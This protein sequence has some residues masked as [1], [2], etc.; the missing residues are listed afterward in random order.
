MP[1]YEKARTK[2]ES[3]NLVYDMKNIKIETATTHKKF[4]VDGDYD[5]DFR[6]NRGY[7][8][9]LSL[10]DN[11][12][13]DTWTQEI[14]FSDENQKI[15]WI[16][17]IYGDKE[18][19]KQGPFGQ[20]FPK[21]VNSTYLGNFIMNEE[22]VTKSYTQAVFGQA[23]IPFGDVFEL[24][25]GGRYQKID[26]EINLDMYFHTI[27]TTT[28]PIFAYN[29]KKTWNAFLPK[30]AFSYKYGE[31]LTVYTSVSKGYMP[32]GFNYL[33]SSGA[34]E[35][36][37]FDPQTSI[38]YEIGTK[39]SGDKY[40]IN[41]SV[42][43]MDIE[44]IH[45]YKSINTSSFIT[46]NAEKA[47][48]QG[49]EIEGKYYLANH[50][51]LSGAIGL[52]DAKYD[53]YD[54]GTK[55]FDGEKVQNTPEYN[56]NLGVAYVTNRG[57]YGR[58]DAEIVGKT[59]YYDSA[60]CKMVEV[61]GAIISNAKLGYKNKSWDIY[62]YIKNIT[63]ESYICGYLS[64]PGTAMIEFNNPRTFGIGVKCIF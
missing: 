41:A 23:M 36:N 10:F 1:S 40:V 32:G 22:S 35:E 12:N 11:T 37:S 21:Y 57:I 55:K 42:F 27:G 47:H 14:K 49:I 8:D 15:K 64:R 50:I 18:E 24:T 54:A 62:G 31:N 39:Y 19:R 60:N 61:D 20:E 45:V 29:D 9:G 25:L 26:K 51:E 46:D 7:Y 58:V 33:A 43:R 30:A 2:S 48:S 52:I 28:N 44:D 6:A 16:A 53:S 56:G 4:N 34:S 3:L 38:N 13:I 17:G 63:D 59:N 5:S